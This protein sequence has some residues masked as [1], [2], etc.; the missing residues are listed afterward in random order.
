MGQHDKEW[1]AL[2]TPLADQK[3]KWW[4]TVIGVGV[5]FGFQRNPDIAEEKKGRVEVGPAVVIDY[6]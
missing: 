2:I 4:V 5:T 6:Q 3:E 1:G